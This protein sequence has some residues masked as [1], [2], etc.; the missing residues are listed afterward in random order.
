[1]HSKIVMLKVQLMTRLA[2]GEEA[3]VVPIVCTIDSLSQ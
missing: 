3:M 1:M 2:R